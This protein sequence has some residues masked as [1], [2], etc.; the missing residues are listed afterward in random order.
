MTDSPNNQLN[1]TFTQ[2]NFQPKDSFDKIS[3]ALATQYPDETFYKLSKRLE[4]IGTVKKSN[5][6]NVK[7]SKRKYLSA[8]INEIRK[9][10]QE[11]RIR[12]VTPLAFD[13]WEKALKSDDLDDVK[14]FPY[15]KL[16]IDKQFADTAPVGAVQINIGQIQALISQ[17]IEAAG[18]VTHRDDL[19]EIPAKSD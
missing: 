13:I 12:V 16:A 17:Q 3:V 4:D 5:T 14:K 1:Q 18:N 9:A 10:H 7:F 6:A 15:V 2:S 8:E 11:R 19:L